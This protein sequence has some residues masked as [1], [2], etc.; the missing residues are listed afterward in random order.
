MTKCID[1]DW[2]FGAMIEDRDDT[3]SQCVLGKRD[4]CLLRGY[5]GG[6]E[7]IC[8]VYIHP[9]QENVV[10]FRVNRYDGSATTFSI[11]ILLKDEA[12]IGLENAIVLCN[13]F[14]E[15]RI[16]YK[17]AHVCVIG[18]YRRM[19]DVEGKDDKFKE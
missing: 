3:F 1:A 7:I 10:K 14:W 16:V 9:I 19:K 4:K 13:L 15:K 6:K 2:L 12:R 8:F 5:V 17:D 18:T 11:F